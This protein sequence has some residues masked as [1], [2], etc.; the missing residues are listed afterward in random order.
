MADPP[1]RVLVLSSVSGVHLENV[2][3]WLSSAGEATRLVSLIDHRRWRRIMAGSP[4]TRILARLAV[5]FVFP[6]LAVLASVRSKP[7]V[8]VVVTNPYFLPSLVLAT[9]GWHGAKV[10]PLV[11]DLF[12]DVL[13]ESRRGP[14]Y[15]LVEALFAR[16]NR[17]AG[18][19]IETDPLLL[20]RSDPDGDRDRV[21]EMRGRRCGSRGAA[22]HERQPGP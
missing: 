6:P 11:Y 12:P 18:T 8:I 4:I 5:T 17:H 16:S 19:L 20:A 21:T 7:E 22:S 3:R 2:E 9:R 14:P 13:T 1:A 10:V 15:R